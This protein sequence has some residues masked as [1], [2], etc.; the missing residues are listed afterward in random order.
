MACAPSVLCGISVPFGTLS[1]TSGQV[2]YVL[3][4]RAPVTQSIAESSPSDLHVLSPPPAFVL[5]QDQTLHEFLA[6]LFSYYLSYARSFPKKLT[7][8]LR[9]LR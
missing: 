9:S 2:A 3:R 7:K 1:P 6:I 4:T 8:A 5:S